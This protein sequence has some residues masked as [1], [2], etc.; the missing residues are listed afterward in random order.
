[1]LHPCL[2]SP[3]VVSRIGQRIAAAVAEHVRVDREGHAGALAEAEI[4]GVNRK[5]LAVIGPPRSEQNTMAPAAAHA[6]GGESA[7]LIAADRMNAW[8][9]SFSAPDMQT[10]GR[11]LDLMPLQSHTSEARSPCRLC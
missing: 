7:E 8:H 6:A 10:A 1:M 11:K 5:L 9:S 4:S 3:R 2:D